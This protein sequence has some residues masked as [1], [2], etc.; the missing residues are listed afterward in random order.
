MEKK[1]KKLYKGCVDI[2][3]YDRAECID[4]K[5]TL[6]I[7][8]DG[9][10]MTLGPRDIK[11]KIKA[12]SAKFTSKTGGEDYYLYSYKWNPDTNKTKDENRN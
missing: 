6:V 7:I 4:K 12:K 11:M 9:Q 5:E 8:H 1:V 3:S 2:K 10:R